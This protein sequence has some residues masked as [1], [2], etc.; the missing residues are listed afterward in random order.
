VL[1]MTLNDRLVTLD[2]SLH[3]TA[4][5]VDR[6]TFLTALKILI[7][8]IL[9]MLISLTSVAFDLIIILKDQRLLLL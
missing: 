5:L 1:I 3:H 6:L 2:T 4:S 9:V 7:C 8:C